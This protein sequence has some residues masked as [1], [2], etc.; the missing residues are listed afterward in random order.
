MSQNLLQSLSDN[1]VAHPGPGYY[2]DMN[3]IDV[4]DLPEPQAKAI[5]D[6]VA[7]WRKYF[8]VKKAKRL[9][10]LPVWKGKVLGRLT[11]EELYGDE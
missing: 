11:R 6:Q 1:V 7:Y 10:E 3:S 5:A 9:V 4:R 8:A 2:L